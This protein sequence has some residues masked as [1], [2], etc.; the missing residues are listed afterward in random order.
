M[1]QRGGV[2]KEDEENMKT[3]KVREDRGREVEKY[4]RREVERREGGRFH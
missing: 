3:S 4:E 2:D 1:V